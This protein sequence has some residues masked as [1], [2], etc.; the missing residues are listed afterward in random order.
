MSD[1]RTCDEQ[2]WVEV[3][4]SVPDYMQKHCLF[5]KFCI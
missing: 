2:A 1:A 5:V 3:T 4:P